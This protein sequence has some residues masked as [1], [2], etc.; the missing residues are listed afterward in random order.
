MS[1]SPLVKFTSI[2]LLL[3]QLSCAHKVRIESIP[4]GAA[5]QINKVD[6]GETPVEVNTFWWPLRQIKAEVTLPGYR[7]QYIDIDKGLRI[8]NILGD[9][10]GFRFFK[11][12]GKRVRQEHTII[13]IRK[14]NQAGTWSPEDAYRLY[15]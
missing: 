2:L 11:L 13:L 10:L 7:N 15:K 1:T 3:T 6:V 8:R 12:F 14:H 5:V 4:T 9:L